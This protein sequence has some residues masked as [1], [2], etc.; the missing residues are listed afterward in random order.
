MRERERGEG[1]YRENVEVKRMRNDKDIRKNYNTCTEN[2]I[3]ES[4]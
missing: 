3:K 1:K 4:Q 2:E